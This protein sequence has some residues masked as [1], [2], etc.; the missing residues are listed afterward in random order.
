MKGKISRVVKPS[1]IIL[2]LIQKWRTPDCKE[3]RVQHAQHTVPHGHPAGR[4]HMSIHKI[5]V[6]VS[7]TKQLSPDKSET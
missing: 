6:G 1:K 4:E 5:P 2:K 7:G 3:K